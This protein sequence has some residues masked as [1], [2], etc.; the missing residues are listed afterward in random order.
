MKIIQKTV[1]K[2]LQRLSKSAIR[3]LVNAPHR[4]LSL[5]PSKI[6]NID[7]ANLRRISK[8]N[9]MIAPQNNIL[10]SIMYPFDLFSP[11]F[12]NANK[13][14][15]V[16][17]AYLLSQLA[18]SARMKATEAI[19][20]VKARVKKKQKAACPQSSQTAIRYDAK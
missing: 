5:Y 4:P 17:R 18:V 3:A 13:T 12:F 11:L 8:A 2:K 1:L 19:K 14:Y 6:K 15:A 7:T 10:A 20:A 9:Q 16:T